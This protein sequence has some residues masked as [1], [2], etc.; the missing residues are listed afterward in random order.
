MTLRTIGQ[1]IGFASTALFI[2][3]F[4]IKENKKLFLMQLLSFAISVAHYFMIGAITGSVIMFVNVFRCIVMYFY[5]D[6]VWAR[7]KIWPILLVICYITNTVLTWDTWLSILPLI[8]T[9]ACTYGCWSRNPRTIRMANLLLGSP[10][11]LIYDI[12]LGSISASIMESLTIL[13][14]LISII[15]YGWKA[16]DR[17]D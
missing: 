17:K 2:L 10:T 5:N 8:G 15:R 14:I 16:L 12:V 11:W 6:K 9:L 4:Q 13:S 7:R 3:S 1:I